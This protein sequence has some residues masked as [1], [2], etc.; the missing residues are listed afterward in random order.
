[1]LLIRLKTIWVIIYLLF[2]NMMHLND[3]GLK[4]K[5]KSIRDKYNGSPNVHLP[6]R[7]PEVL[8]PLSQQMDFDPHSRRQH[9]DHIP[10]EYSPVRKE[11]IHFERPKIELKCERAYTTERKR[12]ADYD[13]LMGPVN[14]H[15][16]TEAQLK[17]QDNFNNFIC[18][19]DKRI[20]EKERKLCDKF[21]EN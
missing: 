15:H 18:D 12:M 4:E 6:S 9:L 7:N 3:D 13:E 21:K 2:G 20:E 1:M 19:L 10:F 17:R 8:Y 16:L 5:L 14:V 11:R